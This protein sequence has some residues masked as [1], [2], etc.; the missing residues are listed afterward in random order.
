MNDIEKDIVFLEAILTANDVAYELWYQREVEVTRQMYLNRLGFIPTI[1]ES[2]DKVGFKL[3]NQLI[4]VI[5]ERKKFE[6]LLKGKNSPCHF[7]GGR[8]NLKKWSFALALPKSAEYSLTETIAAGSLAI[9]ALA[10]PLLGEAFIRIPGQTFK[11]F[12]LHMVI[13]EECRNKNANF[14]GMFF[15]KEKYK[16]YH[17][18]YDELYN[19]GFTK[20]I[21][22][23]DFLFEGSGK[24]YK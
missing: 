11:G 18:F 23:G 3:A 8:N 20:Y 5:I 21:S 16:F 15:P 22:K 1:E 9:T 6:N 13:C 12:E 7:C 14:L 24:G 2:M 19:A 17:P 4:P 10:F